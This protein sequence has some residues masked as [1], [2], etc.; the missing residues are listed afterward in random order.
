MLEFMPILKYYEFGNNKVVIEIDPNNNSQWPFHFIIYCELNSTT[1]QW[2]LF[3]NI[4]TPMDITESDKTAAI[5]E[6][7][8]QLV[9][10]QNESEA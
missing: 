1:G 10:M 7:V 4:K 3:K 8:Y 2:E 5:K 9:K 6:A